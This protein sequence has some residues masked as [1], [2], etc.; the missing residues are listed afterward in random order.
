MTN[1]P[2]SLTIAFDVPVTRRRSIHQVYKGTDTAVFACE[3]MSDL[4][5]WMAENEHH[6]A[7]VVDDHIRYMLIFTRLPPLT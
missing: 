6:H 7:I 3:T 2:P 1:E 4:L 5:A